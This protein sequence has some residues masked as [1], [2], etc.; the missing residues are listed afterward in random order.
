MFTE[1]R[2]ALA[3]SY[4]AQ[5]LVA[6]GLPDLYYWRSAGGKAELDFLV[7]IGR[8]VVPVEVKASLSRRSKSLR[9]YDQQFGSDMLVRAN[10]LNL[11]RDGKICNVPLYAVSLIHRFV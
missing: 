7:K 10:L 5:E 3:E 6:G 4:V 2:G 1:Y 8:T 9:S 11:K